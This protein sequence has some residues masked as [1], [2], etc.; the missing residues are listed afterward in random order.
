M[1]EIWR[2]LD[3]L[4]AQKSLWSGVALRRQLQIA[5]DVNAPFNGE[6]HDA[7]LGLKAAV[8]MVEG[9]RLGDIGTFSEGDDA[10]EALKERNASKDK[11]TT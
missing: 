10:L 1:Y 7:I 3:A 4:L 8:H 5:F 6:V 9:E 11:E 2:H